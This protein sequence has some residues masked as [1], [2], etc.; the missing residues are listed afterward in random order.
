[1]THPYF[2]GSLVLGPVA[3]VQEG[4]EGRHQDDRSHAYSCDQQK[5]IPGNLG[6]V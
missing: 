4:K 6:R 1:M 3:V 2:I 5:Y